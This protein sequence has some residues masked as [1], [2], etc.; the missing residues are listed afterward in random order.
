MFALS[1]D[2]HSVL[3]AMNQTKLAQQQAMLRLTTGLRINSAADDPAGLVAVIQLESELTAVQA[4]SENASRANAMM[5]VADGAL[6]QISDLVDDIQ[7]LTIELANDGTLTVSEKQAKQLEIDTAIASIDRLVGTTTF[8]GRQLLNGTLGIRTSGVDNSKITDVDMT[9]R[10]SQVTNAELNVEV[11]GAAERAQLTFSG[12]TL[13]NSAQVTFTGDLGSV[14]LSFD[15]GATIASV[16]SSINL[17]TVSTGV[18]A[19]ASSNVL[20]IRSE[21]YGE[22]E[23][24]TVDVVTGSFALTG[25]ATSDYGQDPTVT[26]N[27]QTTGV[28][29]LNVTFN[30]NGFTGTLTLSE[31]F[32]SSAGGSETFTAVGGGATFALGYSVT[33]TSTIGIGS[34]LSTNLGSGNLGYLSSLASGG[35]NSP[36]TDPGQ[37]QRIVQ[38]AS[39]QVARARASVGAFQ[40]HTVGSFENVLSS[41]ETSLSSAISSI[42]D[43]D[44]ALETS[45]LTRQNI[46][47]HAQISAL[48]LIGQQQ[49]GIIGLLAGL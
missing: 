31:S 22:D 13:T 9:G 49:S 20:Y 43:T 28:N 2:F 5:S 38:A 16:A 36:L 15:S 18:E 29:G 3:F 6:S 17:N 34:L 27:G 10:H 25:G 23:F 46:L 39:L 26:L 4:A 44:Y 1:A 37:A 21:D 8:N 45:N 47:M 40:K 30:V 41:V 14:T 35:A 11:T 7:S 24:V 42:R 19:V 12:A 48:A 33:D 32:G